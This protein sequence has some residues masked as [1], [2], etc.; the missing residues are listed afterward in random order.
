STPQERLARAELKQ[1]LEQL[2]P[3][4][5]APRTPSSNLLPMNE[6]VEPYHWTDDEGSHSTLDV[7]FVSQSICKY[8]VQKMVGAEWTNVSDELQ[9]HN[10][11]ILVSLPFEDPTPEFRVVRTLLPA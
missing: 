9:G 11:Q 2:V 6:V 8:Q 5:L 4:R 7:R 10:G 1:R 3:T